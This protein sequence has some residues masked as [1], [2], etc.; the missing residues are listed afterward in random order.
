MK[1]AICLFCASL[2][3]AVILCAQSRV[4]LEDSVII[5]GISRHSVDLVLGNPVMSSDE[6]LI[7]HWT[8][9]DTMKGLSREHLADM[10]DLELQ[11]IL[12]FY[13]TEAYGYIMSEAFISTYVANIKRALQHEQG[14][15]Y[16][17][18]YAV[19]RR[20]YGDGLET[21]FQKLNH[22]ISPILDELLGEENI[23]QKRKFG[24]PESHVQFMLESARKVKSNLYSVFRISLVDFMSYEML[25]KASAFLKSAEG[26]KYAAYSQKVCELI[27][28]S[29]E[30]FATEFKKVMDNRKTDNAKSRTS[31][32]EYVSISRS[33]PESF[34]EL[35]RPY[36]E[37]T[38][39]GGKYQGQTRDGR[40]YGKGKL[41]DKKTVYE[42]DF[43][44]GERHGVI[45]VTKSGKKTMTQ[46]WI[47]DRYMKNVPVGKPEIGDVPDAYVY[48]GMKWGYGTSF[49]QEQKTRTQGVFID[50]HL[51]GEGQVSEP[52]RTLAGYFFNGNM[53][54]GV[55]TWKNASGDFMEFKGDLSG[56]RGKGAREVELADGSRK[57]SQTGFFQ[58]GQLDGKGNRNVVESKS[59]SDYEGS[60]AYGKLY[61][62]GVLSQNLTDVSGRGMAEESVYEGGFFADQYHGEGCL[63][64]KMTEIPG[65]PGEMNRCGVLLPSFSAKAIEIVMDGNFDNGTFKDGKISYSNGSWFEGEFDDTGLVNGNLSWLYPDGSYY[66]GGYL[67]GKYHGEGFMRNADGTEYKGLF[68]YGEPVDLKPVEVPKRKDALHH[69]ELLY[70]YDDL[71]TGYGKVAIIRP[72]GVVVMVRSGV[73][74]LTATCTGLFK[75]EVL[76]EGKVDMTDGTWLEGEFDEGVLIEGTGKIIDKYRIV[77]EGEIENGFPHGKGKCTYTDGTWFVGQFAY[78]N[79]MGGTHYAADG[80]VIKVYE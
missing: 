28:L 48:D 64:I 29:S 9:S 26:Q 10:S 24:V 76:L 71:E 14:E 25:Q 2:A 40:P 4:S 36:A 57:E 1:K 69:D 63:Q 70:K 20:G 18:S 74:E 62:K 54:N 79:R 59:V 78:G 47:S 38:V 23:K 44:D 17:F 37:M 41:V 75:G 35:L 31:L 72:A 55:V 58:D 21:L 68:E 15:I 52:G 30:D 34:P 32:A 45:T 46:F 13:R 27:D 12:A 7:M 16:D 19:R 33:F 3:S 56:N 8:F 60:F 42:G 39:A 73:T 80:T 65:N 5:G 77:Y 43:K 61:G 49:D 67:N 22:S 6:R 51:N 11:S 66:E 50:G 53:L